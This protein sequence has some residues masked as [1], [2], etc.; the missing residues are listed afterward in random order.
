MKIRG[1]LA[2]V[3]LGAGLV[4]C[5][6]PTGKS[7]AITYEITGQRDGTLSQVGYSDSPNRYDDEV[8]QQTVD[9]PVG[10]PWKRDVVVTAGQAAQVSASPTGDLT[11]TCR[12]LLDGVR[13]LAKATA[14]GPGE[15][16]RCAKTTDG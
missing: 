15:P 9:G 10:V 2:V 12:I 3:A 1:A 13:E 5:S 16:V 4:A 6:N 8:K 11:L 14:A 7:W